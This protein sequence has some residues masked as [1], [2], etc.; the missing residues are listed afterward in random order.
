MGKP[1]AA[2]KQWLGVKRRFADLFNG[3][4]FN[5]EQ[6]IKENELTKID[7]EANIIIT[8]K[9]NKKTALNRHR[10]IVMRWQGVDLVV[11]AI[12]NQQ[13]VNY[14][15]PVRNMLYDALTYT[16]QVQNQWNL[17]DKDEQKQANSSE[18]FSRFRKTDTLYPVVTIVFYF[19]SETEWDG[20]VTLHE[21]FPSAESTSVKYLLEKYIPDYRLNLLDISNIKDVKI[22]KSDLQIIFGMLKYKKDK[23]SLRKYVYTHK[24]YFENIDIET[25]QASEVL[26]GAGKKLK[27]MLESNKEAGGGINMCKALDD[28]YNEGV[29]QGENS[30]AQL[31]S[32]LFSEGRPEDARRAAEDTEYRHKLMKEMPV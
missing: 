31:I 30:L 14:S 26:L 29:E 7:S 4:I 8:D 3:I 25:C 12:E 11:L 13:K 17:L 19:G 23:E 27:I 9:N 28:W 32:K 1:D 22:F 16:E 24:E 15:M 2:I 6:V 10:D 21:M 18:I 5:G 20:A